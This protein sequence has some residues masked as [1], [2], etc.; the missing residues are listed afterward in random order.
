MQYFVFFLKKA[1]NTWVKWLVVIQFV[2][3]HV[4]KL[5]CTDPAKTSKDMLLWDQLSV[6]LRR[7]KM[8]WTSEVC[9]A[10]LFRYLVMEPAPLGF[11]AVNMSACI[12]G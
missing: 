8:K 5:F 10:Q 7:D 11:K 6:L 4:T 9:V 3:H 12:Y 2:E 1:R